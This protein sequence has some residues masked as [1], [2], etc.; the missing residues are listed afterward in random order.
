MY[1]YSANDTSIQLAIRLNSEAATMIEN[2]NFESAIPK[3]T[4]ALTASTDAHQGFKNSR[5]QRFPEERV[6]MSRK[7]TSLDECMSASSQQS[8]VDEEPD[9]EE[10]GE[11]HQY[12]VFRRC[13]PIPISTET[14]VYFESPMFIYV[15]IIFNLALAHQLLAMECSDV[16]ESA[17]L[18]LSKAAQL[19]ELAFNL[20]QEDEG[21]ENNALFAMANLNNLA[22]VYKSLNNSENAETCFQYLLSILIL[23][24]GCGE[25]ISEFEGFFRNT[26]SHLVVLKDRASAAAA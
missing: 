14:T 24:V 2:G 16:S 10:Q 25:Q 1:S 4:K 8:R 23:F 11:A 22:L 13:I 26:A 3:L 5:I 9:Q 7:P 20:Q 12:Y 15:V 6:G 18:L 17:S 21:M 19:Y